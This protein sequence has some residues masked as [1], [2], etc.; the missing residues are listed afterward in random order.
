MRISIVAL[1]AAPAVFHGQGKAIGGLETFAWK[2]ARLLSQTSDIP[3]RDRSATTSMQN[4]VQ[5]V[6]RTLRSQP[7]SCADGV[8]IDSFTEPLRQLKL[9]VS[10]A[11]EIRSLRSLPRIKK[12]DPVAMGFVPILLANRL[13][14]K[15]YSE[16]SEL[17]N[18]LSAFKPDV[19]IALGVNETSAH[20][21]EI[22]KE[23]QCSL[24]L[25]F[26]SNADLD[27]R[28]YTEPDFTDAYGVTSTQAMQC[29]RNSDIQICQTYH[30]LELLKAA[31][32]LPA[33]KQ[34]LATTDP[35]LQAVIQA[36]IDVTPFRDSQAKDGRKFVLWI[37][38]ADNLH[39]RPLLALEIAAMCPN[40]PFH[41][42]L[43][44][45]DLEIRKHI[46]Q[47]KSPNVTII[48]FVPVADMPTKMS[49]ALAFLSTGSATYE[50]FPNVLLEACAARTPIVSLEDFDNFITRSRSGI[51]SDGSTSK[52]AQA[53]IR[54]CANE[55]Q[56][57]SKLSEHAF[58]YVSKHHT[59]EPLMTKLMK[60]LNRLP[61]E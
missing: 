37:G 7:R 21:S 29:L 48:D 13:L 46:E 44:K 58:A 12:L 32:A 20:L 60:V 49:Q 1:Q 23:L 30:Q 9:R 36:P 24:A 53:L 59:A 3:L 61:I 26:Q 17:R 19:I 50:G 38:R 5:F 14:N 43:N 34:S 18:A 39:K 47:T 57:W 55:D 27:P 8:Q 22:A 51:V 11:I 25:W 6:V 35:K 56:E 15:R 4:E 42:V 54:I 2:L 52:A 40:L 33:L 41:M 16:L 28:L 31:T 10:N 45:G